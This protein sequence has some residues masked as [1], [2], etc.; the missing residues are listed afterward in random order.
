VLY[1]PAFL[2]ILDL[3]TIIIFDEECVLCAYHLATLSGILSHS[4]LDV[5]AGFDVSSVEY[6]DKIIHIISTTR[7]PFTRSS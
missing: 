2:F 1:V 6:L 5:V 4:T 3:I 7:P